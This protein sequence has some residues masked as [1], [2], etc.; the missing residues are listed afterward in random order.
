[1]QKFKSVRQ[2]QRFLGAH[3]VV[4]KLF[5]LGHHLVSANHYKNIRM[6]S[7]KELLLAVA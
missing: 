6:N 4:Y 2:A 7:F 3:A 5:N 1:M